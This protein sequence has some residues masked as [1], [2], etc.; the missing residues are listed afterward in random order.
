MASIACFLDHHTAAIRTCSSSS[1]T[2][3][4]YAPPVKPSQL[5]CRS[6]QKQAA[7]DGGSAAVVSRRLATIVLIGAA[8]VGSKVSPADAA[9]GESANI[10]GKPKTNTDF[11]P[12]IGDGFKVSIPS[13][14]NP[15]KERE[16][17]GQ[18]L[19]YE[20]NF[21]A[22]SNLSVMITPT[23][24]KSITDYGS[25]EDF[26]SQV[27]Y[28]L[29]KQSYF[30]KTDS[31]GGFDSGAT[32][33]IL[34]TSTPVVEGKQYYFLSVLTRTADGDEGGKHQLITATVKDGK[35]YICK[36]QAGDK[37]WFKGAKKFVESA[38]TSFSVA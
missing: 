12:Y 17:P 20:D 7:A 24:K 32:A 29:G 8:A 35:L 5:V 27:D 19:R 14:W 18:V 13:K 34:E 16:F 26:L 38:I 33:N 10:F 1:S 28:L 15:S 31:E 36:A 30:G 22:T 21:N 9:Y 23:D 37:R 25:P 2:T 6:V 11:K 4:R 3:R